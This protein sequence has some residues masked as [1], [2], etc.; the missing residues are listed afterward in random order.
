MLL[1]CSNIWAQA[2]DVEKMQVSFLETQLGSDFGENFVAED[3]NSLGVR[4]ASLLEIAGY[5]FTASMG[6]E[7]HSYRDWSAQAKATLIGLI[8]YPT[9]G[10]LDFFNW[11]IMLAISEYPNPFDIFQ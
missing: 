8:A 4:P 9:V 3:H 2:T 11:Y 7:I 5:A 6:L 10:E 1:I